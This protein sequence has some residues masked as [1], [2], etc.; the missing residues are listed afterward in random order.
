MKLGHFAQLTAVTW[1][2]R[3]QFPRRERKIK[4]NNYLG[5]CGNRRNWLIQWIMKWSNCL[6]SVFGSHGSRS[7]KPS[8]SRF[9]PTS[10]ERQEYFSSRLNIV[11]F[12]AQTDSQKP[13]IGN[14]A[15]RIYESRQKLKTKVEQHFFFREYFPPPGMNNKYPL[16]HADFRRKIVLFP[17][18]RALLKIPDWNFETYWSST[19]W[20][21]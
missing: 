16:F 10:H 8:S 9:L 7:R 12:K 1:D 6:C 18:Q 4:F 5:W 14:C 21:L 17:N 2:V 20:L 3:W 11:W 15:L 13:E 19:G